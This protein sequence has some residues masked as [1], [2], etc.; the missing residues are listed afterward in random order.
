M[1]WLLLGG[2]LIVGLIA[3]LCLALARAAALGDDL[4]ASDEN[5]PRLSGEESVFADR[6]GDATRSRHADARRTRS[7]KS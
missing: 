6:A 2:L 3:V 4:S 1:T 7:R 5:S